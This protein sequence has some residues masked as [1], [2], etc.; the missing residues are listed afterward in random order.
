MDKRRERKRMRKDE[1]DEDKWK[2][3]KGIRRMEEGFCWRGWNEFNL[4]NKKKV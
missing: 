1:K 4:V 2:K 3:W